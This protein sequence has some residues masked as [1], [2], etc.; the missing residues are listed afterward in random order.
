[1]KNVFLNEKKYRLSFKIKA[2]NKQNEE[3]NLLL[4]LNLPE[5]REV[6]IR[7]EGHGENPE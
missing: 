1:M 3:C 5:K 4:K 7:P 2:T 6:L